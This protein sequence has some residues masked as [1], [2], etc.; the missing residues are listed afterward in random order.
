MLITRSG[1]KASFDD[2]DLH[3]YPSPTHLPLKELICTLRAVPSPANI[4]LGV[5]S[6]EVIDLLFRIACAPGKDRVLVCP[7]TYGMY[8][9]CAQVNDV[10]V[11]KVTLDA[12]DGK[13]SLRV[14]EVHPFPSCRPALTNSARRR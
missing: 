2:L 14:D 8:G 10:E 7:P 9:V 13:F 3:R 11:V 6:D 1:L 4:F 12:T 5:G